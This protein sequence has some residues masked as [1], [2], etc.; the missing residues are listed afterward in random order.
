MRSRHFLQP[1]V[2]DS[3]S[4]RCCTALEFLGSSNSITAAARKAQAGMNKTKHNEEPMPRLRTGP[5][6][7]VAT[8]GAANGVIG[9]S[10][11][12]HRKQ[13]ALGGKNPRVGQWVR[14]P[15]S[16]HDSMRRVPR[17]EVF[18]EKKARKKL[19]LCLT[20]NIT[21]GAFWRHKSRGKSRVIFVQIR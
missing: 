11:S 15:R 1:R 8:A 4:Q 16:R 5:P 13:R 10:H 9:R 3:L 17:M 20:L 14:G 19:A 21:R 6:D 7:R 18:D 12:C 2:V